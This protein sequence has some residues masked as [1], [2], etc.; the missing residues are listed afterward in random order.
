MKFYL[1][2]REECQE[3]VKNTEAFYVTEREVNGYKVEMYDYR[4]ASISDFR[5]NNAFELR[6]LTFVY[7]PDTKEWE[8]NILLNKFFNINQTEGWMYEDVKEK[9]IVRVQDKLDGSVISFIRFPNGEIMAK[10]K[11][12]FDSD[13]AKMAQE[14][15]DSHS[16][17]F[18]E[19]HKMFNRGW[20]PI[21]ELIGYEN[22]IVI[23][24]KEKYTLRLLQIR[25]EDGTY[26]TKEE[27]VGYA[28]PMSIESTKEYTNKEHFDLDKLLNLKETEEGYEGFVVTFE[29]GQMA[30]I[31]LD[32]YLH[33]HGLIG[34][35]AFRENLLIESILEETI[36]DVLSELPEGNKKD[37][38]NE[39]IEKVNR[40]FNHLVVQFKK[41]RGEFFNKYNENRKEFA[42]AN[43][44]HPLFGAVMKNLHGKM[45]EVEQIAEKAIKEY[46]LKQTNS[47]GNAKEFLKDI[48]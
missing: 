2:T 34:P 48:K 25:R 28:I 22:S 20:T 39:I 27:M 11:M 31:K 47:L 17:L 29:D 10:S 32:W 33:L 4:L 26:L 9:K 37:N 21:F 6:G 44:K 8:R 45:S 18:E 7:N 40:K 35:D 42:L 38:I 43:R 46:I 23:Q 41:L 16:I 30:K 15:L 24:Y 14:Y 12:S 1:P 13:Q 36:D 3:I 19:L 5:D